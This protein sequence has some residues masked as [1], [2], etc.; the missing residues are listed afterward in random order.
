MADL[1]L[2]HAKYTTRDER[3]KVQTL[4]DISWTYEAIAEELKLQLGKL[5]D[6]MRDRC[7]AVIGE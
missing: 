3:L 6:E 5:I 7:Q 1:S 2:P 4:H